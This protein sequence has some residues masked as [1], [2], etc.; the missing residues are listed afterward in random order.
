MYLNHSETI[1][2]TPV[3]GKIIFHETGDKC[4]KV[5]DGCSRITE[6]KKKKKKFPR[7]WG[8]WEKAEIIINKNSAISKIV[9]F[10]P[11]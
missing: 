3:H 6:S 10:R 4:Q 9:M 5:W 8:F 2:P 7:K 1:S 11:Q